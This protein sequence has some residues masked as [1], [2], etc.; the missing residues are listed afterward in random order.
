MEVL[1]QINLSVGPPGGPQA[2]PS[3]A[4]EFLAERIPAVNGLRGANQFGTAKTLR[5]AAI[6]FWRHVASAR[7]A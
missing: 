5:Q 1:G 7:S 3:G 6:R 2:Q 4:S